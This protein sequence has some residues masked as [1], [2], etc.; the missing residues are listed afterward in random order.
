M[1]LHRLQLSIRVVNP[2]LACKEI[3]EVQTSNRRVVLILYKYMYGSMCWRGRGGGDGI[4]K[5]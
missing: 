3:F 4:G 1:S 5:H 2:K